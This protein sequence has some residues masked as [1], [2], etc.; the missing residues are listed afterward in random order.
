MPENKCQ[1]CKE[2]EALM[3]DLRPKKAFLD[4]WDNYNYKTSIESY[5][6]YLVCLQCFKVDTHKDFYKGFKEKEG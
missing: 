4:Q 5:D 2:K 6:R 3:V 1:R